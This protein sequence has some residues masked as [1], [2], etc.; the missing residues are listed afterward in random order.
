MLVACD[1]GTEAGSRRDPA[2]S[3]ALHDKAL[4][5]GFDEVRCQVQSTPESEPV[6]DLDAEYMARECR[7][8]VAARSTYSLMS[9]VL[10]LGMDMAKTTE[11][12]MTP[13]NPWRN[14]TY[15]SPKWSG[16]IAA[17]LFT[18]YDQSG[19]SDVRVL[20]DDTRNDTGAGRTY[21]M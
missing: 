4:L 11:P 5:M 3:K 16:A 21:E 8:V 2:V 12:S 10:G 18:A 17:G 6:G 20:W 14:A 13:W 15:Y 19:V 9:V 1:Y 7:V